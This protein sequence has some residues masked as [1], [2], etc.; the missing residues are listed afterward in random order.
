MD[1]VVNAT[2]R[3][4]TAKTSVDPAPA[5]SEGSSKP[6]A[7]PGKSPSDDPAAALSYFT[8]RHPSVPALA[9]LLPFLAG[10]LD[11]LTAITPGIRSRARGVN[12]VLPGA[13]AHS[14]AALTLVVG[15]MLV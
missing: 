4:E 5:G 1:P 14:A 10:L 11:I 9:A 3:S 2:R 6:E 7:R 13:L 8:R 15:I 12:H